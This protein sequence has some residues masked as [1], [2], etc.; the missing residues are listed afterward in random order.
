MLLKIMTTYTPKGLSDASQ[1]PDEWKKGGGISFNAFEAM[2]NEVN[3]SI[4]KLL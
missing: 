1:A 3:D 2:L 4:K